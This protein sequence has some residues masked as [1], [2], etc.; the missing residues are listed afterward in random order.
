M[1][2]TLPAAVS[3]SDRGRIPCSPRSP[4]P[5]RRFMRTVSAWSFWWCATAMQRQSCC[6]AS[7][8]NQAYRRSRAAIS[9]LIACSRAYV[10]VSKFFT[11]TSGTRLRTNCSSRL[12]SSPRRWKLQCATTHSYPPRRNTSHNA[13][14]SAPPLKQT[15]TR[16]AGQSRRL[17]RIYFRTRRNKP[18]V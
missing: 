16:S 1:I 5:R 13:T 3:I 6:R 9:M 12:L 8:A 15:R 2:V 18:T 10:M 14:L 4:A 11:M 7:S 17:S